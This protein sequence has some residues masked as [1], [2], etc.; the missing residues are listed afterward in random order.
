MAWQVQL[1]SVKN[2]GRIG[3]PPIITWKPIHPTEG[4][5]YEMESKQAAEEFAAKWYPTCIL[6]EDIRVE[7][8]TVSRLWP[9]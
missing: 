6:G 3:E 1:K 9:V 4:R 7:E 2:T 8:V 5:P